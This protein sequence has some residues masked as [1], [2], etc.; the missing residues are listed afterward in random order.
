MGETQPVGSEKKTAF[1]VSSQTKVESIDKEKET[2]RPENLTKCQKNKALYIKIGGLVFVIL[3]IIIVAICLSLLTGFTVI[4]TE[5]GPPR[6]VPGTGHTKNLDP[7]IDQ[8]YECR[9]WQNQPFNSWEPITID[10]D[11]DA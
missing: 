4:A 8:P 2:L 3:V 9:F 1:E 10:E 11:V 5:G 6:I 7:E